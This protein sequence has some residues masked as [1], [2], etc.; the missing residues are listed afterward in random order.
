QLALG[1]VCIG[2]PV[3]G[4]VTMTNTGTLTLTMMRPEMSSTSFVP[5]FTNP[6]DYPDPPAGVP[7]LE[8]DSATVGVM[9]ASQDP[10]RLEGTLEWNVDAPNAPFRVPVTLEY[11]VSG[12]AVSPAIMKF[13]AIDIGAKS[14]PGVVTL[15]NCGMQPALVSYDGVHASVGPDGAWVL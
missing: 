1:T 9:P 7:L 6:T 10:G 12:T 4:S 14:Q 8:M 15:E 3:M 5:T 11:L 13:G 2:T